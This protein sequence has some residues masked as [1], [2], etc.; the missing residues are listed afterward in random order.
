M[1]CLLAMRTPSCKAAGAML[2]RIALIGPHLWPGQTVLSPWPKDRDSLAPPWLLTGRLLAETGQQGPAWRHSFLPL[3]AH[4]H[5][6]GGQLMQGGG[7]TIS[8]CSCRQGS[9]CAPERYQWPAAAASGAPQQAVKQLPA[10]TCDLLVAVMTLA[11]AAERPVA[12]VCCLLSAFLCPAVQK[13]NRMWYV[14][15]LWSM[16]YYIRRPGRALQQRGSPKICTWAV[17]LQM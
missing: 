12:A 15:Y 1:D 3:Q 14:T 9:C 11:P 16:A 17:P 2:W 6:E 4:L 13:G 10:W 5:R 8:A 7:S